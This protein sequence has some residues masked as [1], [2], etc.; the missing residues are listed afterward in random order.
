MSYHGYTYD[1]VKGYVQQP[2]QAVPQST[3]DSS[4][5][6]THRPEALENTYGYQNG[7]IPGLGMGLPRGE[8]GQSQ[9]TWAGSTYGMPGESYTAPSGDSGDT[10][11]IV[12]QEKISEEDD[13][14][15]E[16]EIDEGE[17]D[18]YEPSWPQ[19][20]SK[21]QLAA[22]AGLS[23]SSN[24]QAEARLQ[25]SDN[26]PDQERG[27]YSPYLSPQEVSIEQGELV[28]HSGESLGEPLPTMCSPHSK[29]SL[30]STRSSASIPAP[31]SPLQTQH[32]Q[33]PRTKTLADARKQA[34]DAILRLW[35]LNVR[36]Q[37]YVDA[38]I[39]ETILQELFLGL[40]FDLKSSDA[41]VAVAALSAPEAHTRPSK[42]PIRSAPISTPVTTAT[43]GSKK[44]TAET[45][46]DRIA[47]RLAAKGSDQAAL[48]PELAKPT[49]A[50][51]PPAPPAGKINL[52]KS[53]LLQQKMEALK[54]EREAK[55]L[56]S[57]ASDSGGGVVTPQ[58]IVQPS[59]NVDLATTTNPPLAQVQD[60]DTQSNK[61]IPGLSFSTS[62]PSST[63]PFKR[64]VASDMNDLSEAPFK[65][66]FGQ[67]RQPQRFL[68]DV[69]DDEDD[70]AMDLDSP[71]MRPASVNKTSSPFKIP[72]FPETQTGFLSRQLSSPMPTPPIPTYGDEDLQSKEKEIEVLKRKIAQREAEKKIRAS[73]PAS[74]AVGGS[75]IPLRAASVTSS[76]AVQTPDA[77]PLPWAPPKATPAAD[78][79]E[80]QKLPKASELRQSENA[81][82]GRSRSRAASEQLITEGRA[83]RRA[84]ELKIQLWRSQIEKAEKEIRESV[85]EEERMRAEAEESEAEEAEVSELVDDQPLSDPQVLQHTG[86]PL[87]AAPLQSA[88]D[89]TPAPADDPAVGPVEVED[90]ES[91]AAA[92]ISPT[93]EAADAMNESSDASGQSKNDA[94]VEEAA[95]AA[96]AS[97]EKSEDSEG[98]IDS[99]DEQSAS[100]EQMPYTST[101]KEHIVSPPR[102]YEE[103]D[104]NNELAGDHAPPVERETSSPID[105]SEEEDEVV[106]GD[107]ERKNSSIVEPSEISG[108]DEDDEEEEEASA[109]ALAG[110]A[111]ARETEAQDESSDSEMLDAS[112]TS[113]ITQPISTGQAESKPPSPREVDNNPAQIQCPMI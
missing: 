72:S 64:P 92:A 81:R 68:I 62:R 30:G 6:P 56:A 69:S 48:S 51:K 98:K 47:R 80:T 53:K 2:D 104:D 57:G 25:P 106:D 108:G 42:S 87:A 28:E 8:S 7:G 14:M 91:D 45:R 79:A 109:E 19:G 93:E 12:N 89:P 29:R 49:P 105:T 50:P 41:K 39:D 84:K 90:L 4:T 18:V 97:S 112:E 102:S 78:F 61:P 103:F 55:L 46:K 21:G 26:S 3:Y 101:A 43:M 96:G 74:P 110:I 83:R 76:S 10:T 65:R 63:T 34:Q 77:P 82:S 111:A 86:P 73:R 44:D 27:S 85:D 37:D 66:P 52:D 58:Q 36:F 31:H 100:E 71:E 17:E 59:Q 1:P 32:Q 23:G 5:Y 60:L 15:D 9:Q 88:E 107:A 99:Q 16:G 33:T 75:T 94:H 35:P 20:S 13:D 24:M 11:R 38:G 113:P 70:A 22:A 54:K 95:A 67:A 40:G